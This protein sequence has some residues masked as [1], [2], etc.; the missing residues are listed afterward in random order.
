[1]VVGPGPRRLKKR[2]VDA[3]DSVDRA[4]KELVAVG[5]AVVERRRRAG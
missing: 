1:M 3:V 4:V 5:A 2:W